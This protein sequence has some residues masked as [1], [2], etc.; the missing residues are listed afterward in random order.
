MGISEG[1]EENLGL[2][3][4]NLLTRMFTIGI[5]DM[6]EIGDAVGCELKEKEAII[7][8]EKMGYLRA[9][10]NERY[11]FDTLGVESRF[12]SRRECLC[13]NGEKKRG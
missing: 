5:E 12:E 8:E 2:R 11:P 13:A 1:A 3:E 6:R 4:I 7:C 9:I 10:S